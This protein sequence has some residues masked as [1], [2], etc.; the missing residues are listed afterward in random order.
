[1]G[2]GVFEFLHEKLR[3]FEQT[4]SPGKSA[5]VLEKAPQKLLVKSAYNPC[6][7]NIIQ[8]HKFSPCRATDNNFQTK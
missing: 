7:Q 4:W 3:Y 6:G 2:E 8:L 5:Q 1:V